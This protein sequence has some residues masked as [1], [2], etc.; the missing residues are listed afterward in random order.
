MESASN[1]TVNHSSRYDSHQHSRRSGRGCCARG[2]WS[3][4]NIAAMVLGFVF[5]WP[6]G[7]AI[8]FWILSGRNVKDIPEAV[9]SKWSGMIGG[10]FGATRNGPHSNSENSVFDEFQQTQY[11]R[12]SEIKEE[13]K[14]RARRFRDF[15]FDAR[16]R[17][18]EKEFSDFMSRSPARE[19]D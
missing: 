18:E 14:T 5:F 2:N 3:W 7:L 4:L 15:R 11:D 1:S 12:I 16:R 19:E 13:I 9:Q 10:V 6:A 8:L 17:A